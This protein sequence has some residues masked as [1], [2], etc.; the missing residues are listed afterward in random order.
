MVE[1]RDVKTREAERGGARESTPGCCLHR[2]WSLLSV[3]T[4]L[5]SHSVQSKCRVY[6]ANILCADEIEAIF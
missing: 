6:K 4:D 5:L 3:Y 2:H 1:G